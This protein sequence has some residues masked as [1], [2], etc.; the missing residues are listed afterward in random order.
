VLTEVGAVDGV[1]VGFETIREGSVCTEVIGS[2]E[3]P[4]VAGGDVVVLVDGGLVDEENEEIGVAAI[5]E[6]GGGLGAEL[7]LDG[8]V[9]ALGALPRWVRAVELVGSIGAIAGGQEDV[10]GVVGGAGLE[11]E[12]GLGGGGEGVVAAIVDEAVGGVAAAGEL[13][14]EGFGEEVGA[15]MLLFGAEV[16]EADLCGDGGEG[17]LRGDEVDGAAEG[18]GAVEG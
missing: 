1:A 5:A 17:G 4:L 3:R 13:F 16:A 18:V 15:K 6:A 14:G 7:L 2:A 11:V 9:P 10:G 8:G 12:P